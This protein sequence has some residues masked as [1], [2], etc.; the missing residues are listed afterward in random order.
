M[1][2]SA[3][4]L[5]V[6][7][8]ESADHFYGSVLELPR[9]AGSV[10]GG[11]LVF[12]AGAA[13]LVIEPVGSDASAEDQSLVGRFTGLSF[14]VADIRS[15][16]LTLLARGVVFEGEPELQ[17]WGGVLATFLDP[18]GNQLQIVERPRG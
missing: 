15:R 9:L 4:R 12:D 11:Y 5:F 6:R 13:E 14:E 1:R 8:L 10:A 7:E 17:A 3:I 18:A 2:L 16:Y